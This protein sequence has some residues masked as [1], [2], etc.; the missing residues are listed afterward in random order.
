MTT[1]G[2]ADF[3]LD[4]TEIIE[5]AYERLGVEVRTGYEL[6]SARRSLDLLMT[7]W[8][9]HQVNLWKVREVVLP[10]QIGEPK[11]LMSSASIDALDA[12]LRDNGRDTSLERI[13]IEQYL[14]T[15]NKNLESR[16]TQF[17]VFRGTFNNSI[18]VWPAP[19]K[20]YSLVFYQLEYIED[21]GAATN[22]VDV[23]RRFLPALISGLALQ[24]ALKNPARYQITEDGKRLQIAGVNPEILAH[25]QARYDRDFMLAREEDRD[26]ASLIITPYVGRI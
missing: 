11:Y 26:R 18:A 8:A 22:K 14:S 6:L 16:P 24:L 23:P 21:G 15:N 7:E 1:S 10:L 5:E 13:S 12:V 3:N 9:N 2:T 25:L 4:I 20:E 17:T 19:D